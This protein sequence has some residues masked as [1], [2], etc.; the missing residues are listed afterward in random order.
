MLK[1]NPLSQ[2]RKN[3]L[4]EVGQRNLQIEFALYWKYEGVKCKKCGVVQGKPKKGFKKFYCEHYC[5]K[6]ERKMKKLNKETMK[7]LGM[8]LSSILP[9][10]KETNH[11]K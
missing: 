6:I 8:Y 4:H 3:Q 5:N 1:E 2:I 9:E 10:Q 7:F 11:K